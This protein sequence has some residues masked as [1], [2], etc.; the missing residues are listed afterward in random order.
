MKKMNSVRKTIDV[1]KEII[2]DE[3]CSH[4]NLSTIKGYLG[5]LIVKLKLEKEG[6]SIIQKGNQSGYDLKFKDIKID[7]KT[8][9]FKKETFNSPFSWGWALKQKSKKRL[10][11][12]THFVCVALNKNYKVDAFYIIK[13]ENIKYFPKGIKRFKGV[14]KVFSVLPN[15]NALNVPEELSILFKK[16][17]V[18][19]K[20]GK[21]TKIK[22]SGN[23]KNV[24]K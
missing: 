11:S 2:Q 6:C 16:C 21:V 5:E 20:E 18:L 1:L 22:P 10:I 4:M 24:L 17:R 19:E 13:K 3:N 12:C 9:S 14:Q 15:T 8:S 7:V 23:L